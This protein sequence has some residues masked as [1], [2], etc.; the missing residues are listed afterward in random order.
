MSA[1]WNALAEQVD[2]VVDDW[3]GERVSLLP[4][5]KPPMAAAYADT[6]RAAQL[7]VL[8]VEM[9]MRTQNTAAGAAMMSRHVEA[10]LIL[11]TRKEAVDLC[12]LTKGDRVRMEER[13]GEI[14][15]VGHV[16]PDTTGRPII[17]L[18]RIKE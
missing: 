1:R 10:D 2:A 14:L 3:W 4:Y 17:H 7:N 15:E 5:V 16:E 13:N 18:L 6:S 12:R 8:A 9:S 11:S